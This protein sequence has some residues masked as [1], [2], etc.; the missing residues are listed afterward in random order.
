MCADSLFFTVLR[1]CI[2]TLGFV[3]SRNIKI[4]VTAVIGDAGDI[5]FTSFSYFNHRLEVEEVVRF[6]SSPP[7]KDFG[8]TIF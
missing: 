5:V 3:R 4:A 6:S 2:S 8:D 7:F 1:M